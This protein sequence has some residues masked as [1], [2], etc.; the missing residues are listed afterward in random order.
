MC[1]VNVMK[2]LKKEIK[3][4][5]SKR[6]SNHYRNMYITQRLDLVPYHGQSN[7][8]S[9]KPE[10]NSVLSYMYITKN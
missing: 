7:I 1:Y 8:D 4:D 6:V 3:Y 10:N 9:R 5:N 2:W